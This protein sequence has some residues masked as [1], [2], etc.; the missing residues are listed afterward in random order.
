LSKRQSAAPS[1]YDP[2]APRLSKREQVRQQKK[3][4]SLMWNIIVLG[5]LGVFL[6]GAVAYFALSGRP[7]PLPGE[8]AIPIEGQGEVPAGTSITYAHTP[9]SSGNHYAEAAPWGLS[10]E[11]VVEGTFVSNLARGGVVFLYECPNDDCA[12]LEQQFQD[13]IDQ[14]PVDSQ[15]NTVKI[16]ATR[17]AGDLPKPIVALAWGHQ[18]DLDSFDRATLLRW[19]DRWVNQGPK[20]AA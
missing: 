6:V 9:P 13:L 8:Q 20:N 11:P 12:A 1:R 7:G 2:S 5:T 14:A 19:Y 16:L 18:L 17:Y 15:F 4:R 3:R 10:P